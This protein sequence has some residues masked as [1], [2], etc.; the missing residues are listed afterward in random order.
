MI[1]RRGFL[2]QGAAMA[3]LALAPGARAATP[4][5]IVAT[6]GMV[7]DLARVL[8][9]PAVAVQGLMGTGVDPHTW[10]A[11]RTDIAALGGA[12]L[13][14]WSGLGLELQ[15]RDLLAR[16]A[17]R[18][19]VVAVAEAVPADRLLADPAYP[20]HPD[21]HV[22]M[23]P[24]RWAFAAARTAEVLAARLPAA[25]PAIAA[26]HDA[27]AAEVAALDTYA[28]EVLAT[29]P[30][31]A[32]VVVTAHDAFSYFG[33]AYGFE[34]LGIQGISTDSEAG[35]ARIGELVSVLVARRIGAVFV[36]SS[37]SPR[38]VRALIEGAAAQGHAVRIG[39]ELYSDAMGPEG[40]Y[41]GTWL[42]M[43]DHN[44]T[45]IARALGGHAP[46]RGRLGRLAAPEVAG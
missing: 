21:P 13:V 29:V 24:A 2:G 44:V 31:E 46:E 39:A 18:V 26:A 12:D 30:P 38:N 37:V 35:L 8:G 28:R 7:A 34:V 11:T 5:G 27:F 14:L 36:E 10:R 25:A 33:D 6:T 9:G 23:D 20:A 1:G 32:R 40:S 19:E 43:I 15:L 45:A 42:G 16:L 17:A 22:W 3:A 41:E 4:L